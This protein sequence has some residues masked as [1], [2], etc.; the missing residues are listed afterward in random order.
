MTAA[1]PLILGLTPT[2][3]DLIV[4]LTH[5]RAPVAEHQL[6]SGTGPVKFGDVFSSVM[7]SLTSAA[8]AGQIEKALPSDDVIRLLIQATI[9][10]M[11]AMGLLETPASPVAS[12]SPPKAGEYLFR[13]YLQPPG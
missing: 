8:A 13:G 7:A 3:L 5:L 6:G 2:I 10:S 1:I 4:R 11:K 9:S 12:S